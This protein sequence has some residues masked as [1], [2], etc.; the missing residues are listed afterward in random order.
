M[1]QGNFDEK[2]HEVVGINEGSPVYS[3]KA[4]DETGKVR[5]LHRNLLLPCDYLPLEKVPQPVTSSKRSSHSIQKSHK[6]SFMMQRMNFLMTK[7]HCQRI[8]FL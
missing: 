6:Q 3:D 8:F 1:V 2:V 5:V 4:E 7:S